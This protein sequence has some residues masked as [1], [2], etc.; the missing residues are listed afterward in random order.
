MPW[1]TLVSE[2]SRAS[3]ASRNQLAA[4]PIITRRKLIAS[5]VSDVRIPLIC[6]NVRSWECSG[7]DRASAVKTRR[8][9][10]LAVARTDARLDRE[11]TERGPQGGDAHT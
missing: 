5:L 8:V 7:W 6:T 9:E 4:Q 11:A 2:R 3:R 10:S 1:D